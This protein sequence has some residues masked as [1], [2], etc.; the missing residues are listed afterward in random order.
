MTSGRPRRSPCPPRRSPAS[1]SRATA[2][3]PRSHRRDARRAW[4]SGRA[5]MGAQRRRPDDDPCGR[6]THARGRSAPAACRPTSLRA[7]GRCGWATERTR[8]QFIGPLTTS[9]SRRPEHARC[10]PPS[11]APASRP[12]ATR[13]HIAVTRDAVWAVNPDAPRAS[14]RVTPN[15]RDVHPLSAGAVAAGDEGVWALGTSTPSRASTGRGRQA[16]PGRRQHAERDR[17]R[18]GRRLG[19]GAL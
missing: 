15:R 19:G 16:D 17:R 4:R 10:A 14:T 11:A 7:P 12:R 2:S 1:T 3:S 18:R 5:R 13:S 6:R 9:V 8:A